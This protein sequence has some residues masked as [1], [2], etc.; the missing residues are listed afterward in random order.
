MEVLMTAN[1]T[2]YKRVLVFTVSIFLLSSCMTTSQRQQLARINKLIR[3]FED[4]EVVDSNDAVV[5][6]LARIGQPAVGP[7]LE[8]LE[9]DS[10]NT[11]FNAACALGKIGD[12]KAVMALIGRLETD[13][14]EVV[15]LA[16][17]AM[18][19]NIGDKRAVQ[20]LIEALGDKS[21][22]VR[23]HAYSPLRKFGETAVP[24]LIKAL[25]HRNKY[26][27]P[28]AASLLEDLKDPKA[29]ASLTEMLDDDYD[30]ARFAAS[31]ALVSIGE[32]AIPSLINALKDKNLGAEA[33]WVLEQIGSRKALDS[34]VDALGHESS[35]IRAAAA[36]ALST[37]TDRKASKALIRLL[38]DEHWKVRRNAADALG[39]IEEKDAVTELIELLSDKNDEVRTYAAGALGSIGDKKALTH[40]I[41]MLKDKYPRARGA[42]AWALGKI[43]DKEAVGHLIE[44]LRDKDYDVR[45]YAQWSLKEITGEDLQTYKSW[46]EWYEKNK[47][48]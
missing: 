43:G 12:E 35:S 34:L 25:K 32:P 45:F 17:A 33:A 2:T 21:E 20:P 46:S 39:N 30:M 15:R 23:N 18:L 31:R 42:A 16:S 41:E 10:R 19:G 24:A 40:L 28:R 8:A 27:R 47:G 36:K 5:N 6:E 48:E 7:L 22:M 44:L 14:D 26:V 3:Q 13:T 1:K 4:I 37:I 38:D 11:R 9:S 29:V